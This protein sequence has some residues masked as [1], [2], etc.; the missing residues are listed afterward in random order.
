MTTTLTKL[1]SCPASPSPKFATDLLTFP[2]PTPA[3]STSSSSAAEKIT[4]MKPR[5]L[6]MRCIARRDQV[7][8]LPWR[9]SWLRAWSWLWSWEPWHLYRCWPPCACWDAACCLASRPLGSLLHLGSGHWKRGK[10]HHRQQLQPDFVRRALYDPKKDNLESP[11]ISFL[12]SIEAACTICVVQL[13]KRYRWKI[14]Q[15]IITINM[16]AN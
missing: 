1:K 8:S 12:L 16:S 2:L 7:L 15:I 4:T 3:T 13:C 5:C 9:D 6:W 10:L 14:N 11:R